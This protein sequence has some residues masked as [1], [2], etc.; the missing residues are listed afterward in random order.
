MI[1]FR[2]CIV[3]YWLNFND[4]MNYWLTMTIPPFWGMVTVSC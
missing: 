2:I 4:L 3:N 1:V